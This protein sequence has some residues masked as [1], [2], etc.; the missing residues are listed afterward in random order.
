MS[1]LENYRAR[2]TRGVQKNLWL[3]FDSERILKE[4]ANATG[5]TEKEIILKGINLISAQT[6]KQVAI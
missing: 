1:T 5:M 2:K 6:L 3:P 4:T